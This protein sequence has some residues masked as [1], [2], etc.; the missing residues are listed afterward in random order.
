MTHLTA[1]ELLDAVEGLLAAD[2]RAHLSACEECQRQLADLSDVL[3]EAMT[4]SVPEP[5]PLFWQHFSERV[6]RALDA[7]PAASNGPAWL[8]W[9]VWLPITVVAALVIMLIAAVP[10][11]DAGVEIA[12]DSPATLEPGGDSWVAFAE[13]VGN[14]DL[15][16]AAAAGMIGNADV[17]DR[18]V[19]ELTAEEQQELTRLLKAELQRAKS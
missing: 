1:D 16:T 5:S 12:R 13:L 3:N 8:R 11:H 6:S 10:R 14:V 7:A 19:L 2:R 15:D 18:A 4:V 9:R 17:V